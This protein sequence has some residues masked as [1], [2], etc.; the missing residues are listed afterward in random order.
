MAAKILVTGAAGTVGS[1]LVK[2]LVGRGIQV[3]AA[4]YSI[5]S[6]KFLQHDLT[7]IVPFDF[8]DSM[9][10]N[11]ALDG[12]EKVY[13]IS[14]ETNDH[15]ALVKNFIDV[16]A[17]AGVH[18]IKQS[19]YGAE[20]QEILFARWHREAEL[21]IEN[22]VA[23]YTFIRPNDYMQNFIYGYPPAGGVIYLPMGHGVI[24]YIDARDIANT[25]AEIL[26]QAQEHVK[27]SYTL[28]GPGA[29][30]V[31]DIANAFSDAS[32]VHVS[33]V[34]IPDETARH[35]LETGG[36]PAWL[37]DALLEMHGRSRDNY[38]SWVT[39]DVESLTQRPPK[40]ITQFAQDYAEEIRQL[41]QQA[42][43]QNV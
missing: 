2:E 26:I 19:R 32:G 14:P 40:G 13:L 24:S 10:F 36:T 31:A 9:T 29:V 17:T 7:E 39:T 30:S 27:K 34:D 25:V 1:Q 5:E 42:H 3:R 21:Y 33:Y 16:A 4:V 37:I 6:A 28:T 35:A 22:T 11:R 43:P 41:T 20:N 38:A 18:V 23:E 12:I 8:K 15:L